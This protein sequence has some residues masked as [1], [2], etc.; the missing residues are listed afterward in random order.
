MCFPSMETTEH[1]TTHMQPTSWNHDANVIFTAFSVSNQDFCR[2]VQAS[3]KHTRVIYTLNL[4]T[5]SKR[6]HSALI[7]PPPSWSSL[8]L[9]DRQRRKGEKTPKRNKNHTH[10]ALRRPLWACVVLIWS[11]IPWQCPREQHCTQILCSCDLQAASSPC[12]SGMCSLGASIWGGSRL[13]T[14]Q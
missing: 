6:V 12:K 14:S 13:R 2:L 7:S 3:H 11:L 1:D 9:A 10:Q 5:D 4:T 8:E